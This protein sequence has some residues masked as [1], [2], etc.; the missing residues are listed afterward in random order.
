MWRLLNR[1]LDPP[2]ADIEF[3]LTNDIRKHT[4]TNCASFEQTVKFIAFLEGK[5]R[6][7]GVETGKPLDGV[8]FVEVLGAA[9]DEDTMGRLEDGGTSNKDYEA[10]KIWIENRHMRLQSRAAKALPKDSD[11]MVY[12]VDAAPPPTAAPPSACPGGCGGCA[13]HPASPAPP[14]G[15]PDPW[16]DSDTWACQPCVPTAQEG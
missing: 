3:H 11:K 8:V 7:F 15:I 12:G 1:K 2:G 14:P 9:L 16:L 6:E 5:R 4:R 10:V 13:L